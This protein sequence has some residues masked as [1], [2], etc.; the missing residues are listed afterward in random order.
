[1]GKEKNRYSF[2]QRKRFAQKNNTDTK[3]DWKQRTTY[4]L[5]LEPEDWDEDVNDKIPV[6]ISRGKKGTWENGNAK[7]RDAACTVIGSI[8]QIFEIAK[9]KSSWKLFPRWS[10]SDSG[11]ESSD[12]SND[13]S[14]AG[15]G[16]TSN[17]WPS[18]GN[19]LE[20]ILGQELSKIEMTKRKQF[21]M[22]RSI[23][24]RNDEERLIMFRSM[25][26][27]PSHVKK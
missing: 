18:Y 13:E 7:V 12:G 19:S 9:S 11:G 2:K 4:F 3:N 24:R 10:E 26:S 23:K 22:F 20:Q 14:P 16:G 27:I 25:S 5:T 21:I 17:G 6:T 8:A 15:K 1:M